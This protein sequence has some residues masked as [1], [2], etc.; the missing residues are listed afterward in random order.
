M[1]HWLRAHENLQ[2]ASEREQRDEE[3]PQRQTFSAGLGGLVCFPQ[4]V[5][6]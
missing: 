2:G 6:L 5:A 3:E 1:L 4:R